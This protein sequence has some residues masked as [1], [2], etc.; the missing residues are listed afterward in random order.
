MKYGLIRK[1]RNRQTKIIGDSVYIYTSPKIEIARRYGDLIIEIESK[2][3]DLRIWET[4][5]NNQ[6]MICGD[7]PLKKLTP[8]NK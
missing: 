7:V 2:G 5:N 1:K 8:L 6:I 3:L 4:D